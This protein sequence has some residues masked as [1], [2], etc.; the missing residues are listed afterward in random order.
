MFDIASSITYRINRDQLKDMEME[1]FK[2]EFDHEPTTKMIELIMKD[3][4]KMFKCFY[5][6]RHEF[7]KW[8][9]VAL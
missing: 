2:L 5:D 6:L 4:D 8:Y 9:F 3:D 7:N 1:I